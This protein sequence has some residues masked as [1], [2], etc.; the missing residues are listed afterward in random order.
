MLGLRRVELHKHLP[1]GE[2]RRN[3]LFSN[4]KHELEVA[5]TYNPVK[6]AGLCDTAYRTTRHHLCD[7]GHARAR[8]RLK[9]PL[10]AM[11]SGISQAF[12]KMSIRGNPQNGCV[13]TP[14]CK[15][16]PNG[17]PA[18]ISHLPQSGLNISAV[19]GDDMGG[20]PFRLCQRDEGIGDVVRFDLGSEQ[21]AGQVVRGRHP[22][23]LCARADENRP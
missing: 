3:I 23:R 22:S 11:I 14:A 12:A 20:G 5:R 1:C 15:S 19:D 10:I 13:A 7:V 17:Q 16:D 18:V 6:P 9:Q 8:K 21:V 4:L 2:S